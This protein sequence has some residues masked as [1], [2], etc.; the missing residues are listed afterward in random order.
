MQF[1]KR[2]S[3]LV[4][5]EEPFNAEPPPIALADSSLTPLDAFYVRGH[6]P[7]PELDEVGWS[8]HFDGLTERDLDVGIEDLRGERFA[9]R[10]VIATLQCA[11]NRRSGLIEV[12]DIPGEAPWGP[13][14]TGTAT[15]RGVSLKEILETV[16][17]KPEARYV[18]FVGADR[19]EEAEPP[20]LYGGSIP[21]AKAMGEE[22]LLAH[23]MNGE[24]LSAVHGAPVRLV[25]PGY[26]GARSVKWVKRIELR[27]EPWDGYFQETTYRLLAPEQQE[28][29]GVGMELGEVALNTDILAPA[30]GARVGTDPVEVRGYAFAGGEREIARVDVS[31]DGGANWVQAELLEDL[32]RW[33]WRLWR[34]PLTL[35][36][37]VHEILARAWDSAGNTQP[38]RP[39][40]VWNPKGYVNSSWARIRVHVG[41]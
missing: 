27:S 23:E 37:G 10:E 40:S 30:D 19:S 11:G 34:T 9:Q 28:G 35:P 5:E 31:T 22:V 26:I 39:E 13:G 15:W 8:L 6:A 20:Q 18:A 1:G 16:G 33:A 4:H 14:A 24:R 12:R 38:E 29:P 36:A 32:G 17:V 3:M 25:V 7:V 41:G 21:L 2:P